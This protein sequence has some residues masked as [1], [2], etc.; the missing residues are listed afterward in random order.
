MNFILYKSE[1]YGLSII[2]VQYSSYIENR[3][4]LAYLEFKLE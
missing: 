1:F 3:I 2:I 4:I